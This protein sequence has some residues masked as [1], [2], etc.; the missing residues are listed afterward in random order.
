MQRTL[1]GRHAG[2]GPGV[3]PMAPPVTDADRP[4]RSDHLEVAGSRLGRE[5]RGFCW[6]CPC[7][8][9]LADLCH[10]RGPGATRSEGTQAPHPD[11]LGQ[12]CDLQGLTDVMELTG[13]C[14]LHFPESGS[15]TFLGELARSVDV[16]RV[17][18]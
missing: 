13:F 15:K 14:H 3:P 9:I 12:L 7:T 1:G 18:Q 4:E 10:P 6:R 16:R 2:K 5:L 17:G 8:L 11:A